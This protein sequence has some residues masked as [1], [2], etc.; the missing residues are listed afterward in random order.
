MLANTLLLALALQAA[1]SFPQDTTIAYTGIPGVLGENRHIRMVSHSVTSRIEGDHIVTETLSLFRNTGS[2]PVT[3]QV[4]LPR[5]TYVAGEHALPTST[6]PAAFSVTL[7]NQPLASDLE[8][9]ERVL[10]SD[11]VDRRTG[12]PEWRSVRRH[13]VAR[14]EFGATG[15]RALRVQNSLPVG[16]GGVGRSMRLFAYDLENASQW[17][18]PMERLNLSLQDPQQTIFSVHERRPDLGWQVGPSGAFFR[19]DNWTPGRDTLVR[20]SYYVAD[21]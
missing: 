5:Y 11:R 20:F 2:T 16:R 15:T 13:R 18:G 1:P 17:V 7:D 4:T 14:I 6:R 9:G 21:L 8:A 12:V 10:L 3:L 19:R